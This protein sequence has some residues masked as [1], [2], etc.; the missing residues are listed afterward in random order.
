MNLCSTLI[1]RM[2]FLKP[3]TGC[4]LCAE[5]GKNTTYCKIYW[6]CVLSCLLNI[7]D[8]QSADFNRKSIP[9]P[10]SSWCKW[11]IVGLSVLVKCW[12]TYINC[13]WLQL[14]YVLSP[15]QQVNEVLGSIAFETVEKW[16]TLPC[17]GFFHIC[18]TNEGW[19]LVQQPCHTSPSLRTTWHA[20]FWIHC[21]LSSWYKVVPNRKELQ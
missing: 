19:T 4:I 5:I 7:S 16:C 11:W 10:W 13:G 20:M 6:R 15:W 21:S 9:N 3:F 17:T 2:P 18:I 14:P 12:Q 1:N 8:I